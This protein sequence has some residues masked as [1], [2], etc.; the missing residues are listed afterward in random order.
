MG[1]TWG[2]ELRELQ[3]LCEDFVETPPGEGGDSWTSICGSIF[4]LWGR[5]DKWNWGPIPLL[6]KV[7]GMCFKDSPV[8]PY[9]NKFSFG[10]LLDC[11]KGTHQLI[12]SNSL[13]QTG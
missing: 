5:L 4:P 2:L 6:L 13:F 3:K 11:F 1:S 7:A 8:G 10:R 12:C 9:L